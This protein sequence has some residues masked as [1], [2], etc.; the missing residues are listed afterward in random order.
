MTGYDF[1]H[2]RKAG[3]TL[4]LTRADFTELPDGTLERKFLAD[5]AFVRSMY[6]DFLPAGSGVQMYFAAKDTWDN[7]DN[8]RLSRDMPK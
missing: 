7:V 4:S 2:G 8:L 5:D 3:K 1:T 6:K